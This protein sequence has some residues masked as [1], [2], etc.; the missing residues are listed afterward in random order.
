MSCQGSIKFFNGGVCGASIPRSGGLVLESSRCSTNKRSGLHI[1]QHFTSAWLNALTPSVFFG[2][3]HSC[4]CFGIS[5]IMNHNN[6]LLSQVL[7]LHSTLSRHVYGKTQIQKERQILIHKKIYSVQILV[8]L[9]FCCKRVV[10]KRPDF[11][12]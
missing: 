10:K 4:K 6:S 9:L 1:V 7:V 5:N 3:E 2:R 11:T 12:S 8:Y